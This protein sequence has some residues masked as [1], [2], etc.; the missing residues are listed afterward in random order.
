MSKSDIQEVLLSP[1][2]SL[3]P[4]PLNHPI[5]FVSVIP[6]SLLY[7]IQSSE[8]LCICLTPYQHLSNI[9]P[10]LDPPGPPLAHLTFFLSFALSVALFLFTSLPWSGC[11]SS[12]PLDVAR[13]P[14]RYSDPDNCNSEGAEE[15]DE[16]E[17]KK[18]RPTIVVPMIIIGIGNY[19]I[20]WSEICSRRLGYPERGWP[21][22]MSVIA[23]QSLSSVH[24]GETQHRTS[25]VLPPLSCR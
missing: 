1:L 11:T 24:H 10:W 14:C 16:K 13:E 6:L 2:S 20:E 7:Y 3:L 15:D 4:R 18:S 22:S 25:Q 19:A 9:Y 8:S 17:E 12:V 5:R 21:Q 23:E